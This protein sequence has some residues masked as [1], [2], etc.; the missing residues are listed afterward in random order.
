MTPSYKVLDAFPPRCKP[1]TYSLGNK[2][3]PKINWLSASWTAFTKYAY[4][5][6]QLSN[7]VAI[8][9]SVVLVNGC[10]TVLFDVKIK[11]IITS[12]SLS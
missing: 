5:Q 10:L 4:F 12:K 11:M 2:L 3:K 1:A 8:Y 6:V 7:L 9:S